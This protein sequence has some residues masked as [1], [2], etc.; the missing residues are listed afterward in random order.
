MYM[1]FPWLGVTASPFPTV[2]L[3]GASVLA[4]A[5]GAA[6]GPTTP[7]SEEM[8]RP[9]IATATTK[10][11]AIRPVIDRGTARDTKAAGATLFS[12][13]CWWGR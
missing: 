7:A 4:E 11:T 3:Q 1:T 2:P 8:R 9:R 12:F 5:L 6:P 13:P 10:R